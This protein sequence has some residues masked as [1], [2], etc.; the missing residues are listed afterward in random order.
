MDFTPPEVPEGLLSDLT[1]RWQQL[2]EACGWES[3]PA[4]EVRDDLI[5]RHRQPHRH[6]HTLI[7]VHAVLEALDRLSESAPPS[8][9]ARLAVWFHDAVYEGIAAADEEASAQLAEQQ[10]AALGTDAQVVARAAAM[11]R[12]TAGHTHDSA[13]VDSEAAHMLDADLSILAADE[14]DYDRYVE[15]V[16]REYSHVPD[17]LFTQGRRAVV[18]GLLT[19][20]PL[21]LS[22]E[23]RARFDAAARRNLARELARLDRVLGS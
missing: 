3:G 16:R 8:P 13:P 22:P 9:A 20:D 18:T 10:L 6:Y 2:V 1:E 19:R 14:A 21:Y 4:A 23:G 5:D 12:A 17:D 11:V 7:H 15:Q